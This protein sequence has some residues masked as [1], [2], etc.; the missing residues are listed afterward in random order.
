MSVRVRHPSYGGQTEFLARMC[1]LYPK[2]RRAKQA[3]LFDA[4]CA[5]FARKSSRQ[6]NNCPNGWHHRR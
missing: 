3:D 1:E 5:S 4:A 6:A 2:R